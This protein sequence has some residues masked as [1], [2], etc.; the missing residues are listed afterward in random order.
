M[1]EERPKRSDQLP[2]EGPE[3]VVPDDAPGGSEEELAE[4]GE[5]GSGHERQPGRIGDPGGD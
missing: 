3:S 2:E 5:E 1:S 4:Q